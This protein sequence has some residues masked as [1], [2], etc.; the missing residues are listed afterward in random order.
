[1]CELGYKWL[2]TAAMAGHCEN[3]KEYFGT[4]KRKGRSRWLRNLTHNSAAACMLGLW[5]RIPPGKGWMS[6][7]NVVRCQVQDSAEK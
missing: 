3:Y 4:I 5:V 2:R 7:L 6:L 1:M